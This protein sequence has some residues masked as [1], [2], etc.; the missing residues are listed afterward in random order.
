MKTPY[1]ALREKHAEDVGR[2]FNRVSLDLGPS[3]DLPTDQRLANAKKGGTDDPG[4]QA[5]LFQYGRYL[6][7][8]SS[9]AG[10]LPANLQGKWNQSIRPPWRSDY[11]TTSTCR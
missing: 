2:L 7:I 6:L 5:L 3:L 11:H 8:A 10:G 4:F 9:R 1:A